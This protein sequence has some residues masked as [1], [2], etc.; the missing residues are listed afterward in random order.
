MIGHL[1][2]FSAMGDPIGSVA[3]DVLAVEARRRF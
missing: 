2:R 3:T 1:E